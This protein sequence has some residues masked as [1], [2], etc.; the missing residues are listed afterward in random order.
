VPV[1]LQEKVR[2]AQR[3]GERAPAPL[4]LPLLLMATS[5]SAARAP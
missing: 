3:R 2:A 4:L 5:V 1:L